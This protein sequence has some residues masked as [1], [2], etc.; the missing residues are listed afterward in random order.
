MGLE[1]THN[2]TLEYT[3]SMM[4]IYG[5]HCK[6][7]IN[8]NYPADLDIS[9]TESLYQ[10]QLLF[11]FIRFIFILILAIVTTL[12]GRKHKSSHFL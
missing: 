7:V 1:F 10:A 9:G 5:Q 8:C 12:S 3:V 4:F 2:F 11:S 6:S